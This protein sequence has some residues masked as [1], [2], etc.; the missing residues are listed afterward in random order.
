[1]QIVRDIRAAVEAQER[2]GRIIV[3]RCNW[4]V[5]ARINLSNVSVIGPS[6]RIS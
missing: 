6:C 2:F 3:K 4:E 1:M 5:L